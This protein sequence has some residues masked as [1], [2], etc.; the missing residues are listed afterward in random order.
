MVTSSDF[1]RFAKE[2]VAGDAGWVGD[3]AH[4]KWGI[5]VGSLQWRGKGVVREAA[6]TRSLR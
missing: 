5:I 6:T 1:D 2:K 4:V 3:E